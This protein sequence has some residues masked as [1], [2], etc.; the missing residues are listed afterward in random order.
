MGGRGDRLRQPGAGRHHVRH[1]LVHPQHRSGQRPVP[2]PGSRVPRAHFDRF[3]ADPV[4]PWRHAGRRGRVGDQEDPAR[5]GGERD[6]ADGGRDVAR[7]GNEP[8]G[9]PRVS[10]RLPDHAGLAVM[11]RPLRVEQVRDHPRARIRGRRHLSGRGV[12]VTLTCDRC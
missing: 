9:Q 1:G 8:A 4:P 10:E 5:G 7:V 3:P 6:R 12:T 2:Q 11:Q